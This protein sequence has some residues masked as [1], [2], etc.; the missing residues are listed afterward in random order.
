MCRRIRHT[1]EQGTHAAKSPTAC[2]G[3]DN[4]VCVTHEC[5]PLTKW[6]LPVVK[7]G[8]SVGPIKVCWPV[9]GPYVIIVGESIAPLAVGKCLGPG[10]GDQEIEAMRKALLRFHLQA[11]VVRI[12]AI[13]HAINC[14]RVAVL[15]EGAPRIEISRSGNCLVAIRVGEE[16]PSD[17]SDVR[18]F[19]GQAGN[20]LVLYGEVP[21]IR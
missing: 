1:R 6:Q 17:V 9:I 5:A 14:L 11:V 20:D 8:E 12:I 15:V 3:L 4:F 13:T 19:Y 16:M 21:R 10:I 7:H 18:R 2:D